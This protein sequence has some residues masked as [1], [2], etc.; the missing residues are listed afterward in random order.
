MPETCRAAGGLEGELLRALLVI[1]YIQCVYYERERA[2]CRRC[3]AAVVWDFFLA[4]R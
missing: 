3:Y 4:L 2:N 1:S